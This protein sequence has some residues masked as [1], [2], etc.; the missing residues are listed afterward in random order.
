MDSAYAAEVSFECMAR[1]CGCVH[2]N[3][4]HL[5][6]FSFLPICFE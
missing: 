6:I 5:S 3:A 2:R 1:F 4:A